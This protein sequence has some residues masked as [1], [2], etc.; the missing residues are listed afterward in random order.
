MVLIQIWPPKEMFIAWPGI[1]MVDQ[2]AQVISEY[3]F[4]NIHAFARRMGF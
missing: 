1:C 4:A 2:D 3:F